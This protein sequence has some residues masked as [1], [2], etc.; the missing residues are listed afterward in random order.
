M[1]TKRFV[2]PLSFK[3]NES[4]QEVEAIFC[5]LQ[6]WDADND[7]HEVGC[8]GR[9]ETVL[10][11]Y[12]HGQKPCG[13]GVILERGNE[14]VFQ[15]RYWD[16]P[17]GIENYQT[18]KNLGSLAEWSYSYNVEKSKPARNAGRSGRRLQAVEVLGVSCVRKGAGVNTHTSF[19]KSR[20]VW[21]PIG[22]PKTTTELLE[23]IEETERRILRIE[24]EAMLKDAPEPTVPQMMDDIFVTNAVAQGHSAEYAAFVLNARRAYALQDRWDNYRHCYRW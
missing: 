20:G 9:Q 19:I 8:F 6:T 14:A 15:G 18:V 4:T 13:K 7:F 1:E 16:T 10:E 24:L 17:L 21:L 22:K 12:Q 3:A 2:R 11:D 23:E 5:T